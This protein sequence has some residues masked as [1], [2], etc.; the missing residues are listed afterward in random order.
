MP[1]CFNFEIHPVSLPYVLF[2]DSECA[3]DAKRTFYAYVS[4]MR[5]ASREAEV[6]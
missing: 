4:T 5:A 2:H 3:I 1:V 6:A